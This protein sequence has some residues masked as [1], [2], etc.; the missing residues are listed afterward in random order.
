[1]LLSLQ[2]LFF[3]PLCMFPVFLFTFVGSLFFA[4][5]SCMKME[6]GK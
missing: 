2:V 3:A 5:V 6:G 4:A 1:M